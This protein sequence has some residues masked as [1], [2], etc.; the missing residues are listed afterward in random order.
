MSAHRIPSITFGSILARS[1][2]DFGKHP[3]D[4]SIYI[5][6]IYIERESESERERDI[7]ITYYMSVFICIYVY[8]IYVYTCYIK[9]LAVWATQRFSV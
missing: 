2:V 4:S 8:M 7:E 9:V 6:S 5:Y 3:K 1:G